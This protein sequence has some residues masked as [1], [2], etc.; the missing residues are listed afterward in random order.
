MF[1]EEADMIQTEMVE[2]RIRHY[3]DAGFK[4]RQ[5]ETGV[6][7]EDA[8]DIIPCRYTYEETDEPI[9]DENIEDSE[10]LRIITGGGE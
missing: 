2:E 5:V 8:V 4:I 6:V 10:A 9:E 7:Y 1:R 3:S